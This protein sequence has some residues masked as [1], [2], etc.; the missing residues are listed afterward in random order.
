MAGLLEQTLRDFS[1]SEDEVALI[2]SDVRGHRPYIVSAGG[3]SPLSS[4][5]A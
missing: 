2:M 3:V 4:H 5:T 1:F